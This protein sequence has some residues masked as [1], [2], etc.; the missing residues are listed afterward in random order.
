[1]SQFKDRKSYLAYARERSQEW[2]AACRGAGRFVQ[3]QYARGPS[4]SDVPVD[5]DT[6]PMLGP[7]EGVFL[8]YEGG[9]GNLR[10]GWS[11]RHPTKEGKPFSKDEGLLR[12]IDRAVNHHA[13]P[14]FR[15]LPMR[16]DDRVNRQFNEFAKNA[17]ERYHERKNERAVA[18]AE[19]AAQLLAECNR[20]G[21]A[22]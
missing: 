19:D 11:M 6:R 12:A 16:S 8:A 14:R 10:F 13:L 3:Y 4:R 20:P 7:P 21:P 1:M 9:E 22:I 2:L 18:L 17:V 5:G 15:E